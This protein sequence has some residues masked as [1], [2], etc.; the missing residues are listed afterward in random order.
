M[1]ELLLTRRTALVVGALAC[2]GVAALL[3]LLAADVAR[4]RE[5]MTAGDVRY[6]ASPEADL[7]Q[8]DERVPLGIAG[9]ILG[10]EDDVSFRRAV[11]ALRLARLEDG[12]ISDPELALR[13][14]EAQ[15]R[16]EAISTGGDTRQRRSRAAGLLGVLGIARL[17]TEAQD[18]VALLESTIA[19][20]HRALDL[21]PSNADAKFNLELALQRGRGIQL[22]EG[23]GGTNPAPG[24]AGA[25][26]AGAGDPGSGY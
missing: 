8:P 6:Q 2:F 24:G 11:R 19:S 21:D 9:G 10:V 7:W 13:R 18:R 20:L 3:F 12:T 1:R 15:A 25:R 22:T 5:A 4:W 16:L 23:A 26:G 14:N 17:A